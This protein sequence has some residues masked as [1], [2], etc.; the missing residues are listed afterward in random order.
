MSSSTPSEVIPELQSSSAVSPKF[1]GVSSVP[2]AAPHPSTVPDTNTVK[3]EASDVITA[4]NPDTNEG[5]VV[6]PEVKPEPALQSAMDIDSLAPGGEAARPDD[7]EDLTHD[8]EVKPETEEARQ[9]VEEPVGDPLDYLTESVQGR[10]CSIAVQ[11]SFDRVPLICSLL[12]SPS[13][14]AVS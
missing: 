1:N 14:L 2:A 10:E 6:K 12:F 4:P 8:A 11:V 3:S 7:G 9:D 13:V 5:G